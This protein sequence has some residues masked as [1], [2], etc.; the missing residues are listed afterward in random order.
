MGIKEKSILKHAFAVAILTVLLLAI[1]K[2]GL[3][4]Y[5]IAV[6][7]V[8]FA[9]FALDKL[10][11]RNPDNRRIPE[12]TFYVLAI[13][14]AFPALFAGRL[15]FKHKTSKTAFVVPMYILFI[16]QLGAILWFYFK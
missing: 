5:L 10:A 15:I 6:N 4:S 11:S 13:S 16:L 8:L 7:L 14:G 12:R 1:I 3:T 2:S 9:S